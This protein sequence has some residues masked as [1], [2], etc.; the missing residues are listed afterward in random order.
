MS[1]RAIDA[2]ATA[3]PPA[4]PPIGAALEAE[5]AQLAPTAARRPRRQLAIVAG[6]SL[7]YAAGL[8]ALMSIRRDFGELP[9]GWIVGAALAWLLGIVIPLYLA[10]VPRSMTPRW[11]GA[12]VAAAVTSV[13][14][15]ALGLSVHPHGPS[16]ANYGWDHFGRGHWCMWL[17]LA[18]ALVPVILGTMFLRGAV[19]VASRWIAAALGTGGG[20]VGGLLLHM[21]CRIADAQHIGLVHGGVVV[22]AAAISALVVPRVIDRPYQRQ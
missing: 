4:P 8:L 9:M 16:S 22:V 12:A 13:A 6:V 17:G 19:P 3:P 18:T 5:L 10:I 1:D 15:I 7:A 21:H 2:L 14:F 20:C 11:Q